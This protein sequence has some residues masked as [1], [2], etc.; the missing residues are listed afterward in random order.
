MSRSTSSIVEI[1]CPNRAQGIGLDLKPQFLF[2]LP[3]GAV[4]ERVTV[5]GVFA[6]NVSPS[7]DHGLVV[8]GV[9]I[10]S[11]AA[12]K[13]EHITLGFAD[14]Y[15]R[16]RLDARFVFFHLV[17][18]TEILG[19]VFTEVSGEFVRLLTGNEVSV[20]ERVRYDLPGARKNIFRDLFF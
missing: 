1:H 2:E 12:A 16:K 14:Q 17:S 15:H 18:G 13:A 7:P 4:N 10:R 8:K 9:I 5:D 20:A 11:F 3:Y 6:T 19:A